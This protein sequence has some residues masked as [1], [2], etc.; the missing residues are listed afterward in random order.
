MPGRAASVVGWYSATLL[1][2][3]YLLSCDAQPRKK[4]GILPVYYCK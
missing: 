2:R 4:A 3:G 1:A